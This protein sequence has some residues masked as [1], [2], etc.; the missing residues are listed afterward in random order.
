MKRVSLLLAA[1]SSLAALTL[2]LAACSTTSSPSA[3]NPAMDAGGGADAAPRSFDFTALHQELFGGAWKSEGVVVLYQGSIVYEE[4]ASGFDAKKRHILYSA[5]KS[6]GGALVGI[7]IADGAMKLTDSV[8]TFVPPPIGADPKLCDTTIESLLQMTSGMK[9][10]EDY[11][12]DPTTS[13]VLQMLYGNETD[14]GAYAA[15]QPRAADVATK[16]SYSSGDA[17]L[18]ARALRGALK[19]ED[20]RAWAKRKLFDPA[21]LTS[22][23]FESDRSGTLVFSSSCFMT[24][25][26]MAK[27]GQLYLDDG[28]SGATRVLPAG[29]AAY[30]IKPAAPVAVAAPRIADAGAGNSG[31]SYGAS[32]W[33]NAA[34]STASP[35][36]WL[37]PQ[38][39]VDAFSAEGHYGQKI[40]IV[41]SRHLVVVRVGNDRDPVFDPGPM[42][43]RAVEAIDRGA[44]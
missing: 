37:Y 24:A 38:A 16:W 5:S 23:I 15:V 35:D 18:L 10:S 40:F 31:G 41:P 7:A 14:M 17:N 27:F 26:D 8:C 20:P 1:V 13:N 3:P 9:W 12:S 19:S 29:W 44:Q 28:M 22:A 30:S 21:G 32:F 33:L 42:V 11:G 34:S 39:P 6:I 25:R 4:Y 2:E 43:G 36:T